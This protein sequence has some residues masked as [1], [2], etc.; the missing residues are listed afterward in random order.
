MKYKV[1]LWQRGSVSKTLETNDHQ[2]AREKLISWFNGY[3]YYGRGWTIMYIDDEQITI[4]MKFEIIG[5][6]RVLK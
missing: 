3:D 1:E 5:K 6:S 2:E 4:R